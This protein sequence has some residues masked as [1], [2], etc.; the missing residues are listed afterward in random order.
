[1]DIGRI[2]NLSRIVDQTRHGNGELPR[3]QQHQRKRERNAPA[4]VPVYTPD[5]ELHEDQPPKIDVLV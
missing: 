5:G 3:K 4:A 1:M 2:D